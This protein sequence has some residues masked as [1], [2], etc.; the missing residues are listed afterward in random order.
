MIS[1]HIIL[2]RITS[3][4]TTFLR[5]R[6]QSASLILSPTIVCELGS[7]FSFTLVEKRGLAWS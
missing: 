7:F 3:D 1:E 4:T 2:F 6:W 5:A